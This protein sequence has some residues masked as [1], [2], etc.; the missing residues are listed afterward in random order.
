[1][2]VEK[3]STSLVIREM[4]IQ[5]GMK[6][7]STQGLARM[8]KD[9]AHTLLI[10]EETAITRKGERYTMFAVILFIITT[11]KKEIT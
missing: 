1:M 11:K 6:S 9:R 3:I 7:H 4:Q 5:T 2:N 8:K 10:G